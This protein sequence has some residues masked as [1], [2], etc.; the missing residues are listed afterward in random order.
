LSDEGEKE[1]EEEDRELHLLFVI[2]KARQKQEVTLINVV[3]IWKSGD[4]M[5]GNYLVLCVLLNKNSNN[6]VTF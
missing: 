2:V 6:R 4:K 3:E 1:E 5:E